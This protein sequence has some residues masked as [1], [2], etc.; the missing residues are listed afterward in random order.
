[1]AHDDTRKTCTPSTIIRIVAVG[2]AKV[3]C[4]TAFRNNSKSAGGGG[5][6]RN[7]PGLKRE[8]RYQGYIGI[9]H[10]SDR[11]R[12]N[13]ILTAVRRREGPAQKRR[14]PSAGEAAGLRN[15]VGNIPCVTARLIPTTVVT[16]TQRTKCATV[17][18]DKIEGGERGRLNRLI[19]RPVTGWVQ[20]CHRLEVSGL[21]VEGL[22]R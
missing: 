17:G 2:T 18:R 13:H 7:D 1:M 19:Q 4:G 22:T 11:A 20:I 9:C 16:G 8:W 15:V 5:V 14:V 21:A 6:A 12:D 10:A 3:H